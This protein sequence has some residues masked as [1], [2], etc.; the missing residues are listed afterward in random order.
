MAYLQQFCPIVLEVL[1]KDAESGAWGSDAHASRA[2]RDRVTAAED[3]VSTLL[4]ASALSLLNVLVKDLS[5]L[6]SPYLV[7]MLGALLA[8][9]NLTSR[10]VEVRSSHQPYARRAVCC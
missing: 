9:A 6:L 2:A 7:D 4:R 10:A 5:G 3:D 1:A 8:P